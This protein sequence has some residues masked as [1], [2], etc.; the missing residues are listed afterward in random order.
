MRVLRNIKRM[1]LYIAEY[2]PV[3]FGKIR[4]LLYK[5]AGLHRVFISMHMI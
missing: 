4:M 2:I 5:L 3:P 1:L